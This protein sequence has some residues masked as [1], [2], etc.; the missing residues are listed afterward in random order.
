MIGGS[1]QEGQQIAEPQE[2]A[3]KKII[4][5]A[6]SFQRAMVAS[7]IQRRVKASQL[8]TNGSNEDF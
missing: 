3:P 1:M 5:L 4:F 2:L 8:V 6:S 7:A